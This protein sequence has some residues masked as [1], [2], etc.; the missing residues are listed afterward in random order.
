[1]NLPVHKSNLLP[2][3]KQVGKCIYIVHTGDYV[4]DQT[5]IW[6]RWFG[7][8]YLWEETVKTSELNKA[9]KIKQNRV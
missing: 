9:F 4:R 6:K 7:S 8:W 3:G 2:R 1:M 5:E